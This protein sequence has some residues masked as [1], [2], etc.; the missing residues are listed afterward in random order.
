MLSVTGLGKRY[1]SKWVFR[2]VEFCVRPGEVLV[3]TG[4][5]GS[6]K[7]TLLKILAGLETPSSGHV[8]VARVG[9]MSPELGLYPL[10]TGK[11]H[12]ELASRLRGVSMGDLAAVGLDQAAE[13]RI[14][15]Y[16]TGMKA[17]L[18]LALA[19]QH[20]PD[21]L[22]LDEPEAGLDPQGKEFVAQIVEQHRQRGVTVLATNDHAQRRCGD[23]ELKLGE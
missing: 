17:R 8:S 15:A 11:E 10:L 20:D 2:N 5:N 1:G 6:G 7:S 19:M 12:M 4:P 13:V 18:R 21:V 23:Y 16:S 3:V 9:Y 14:D 22:L